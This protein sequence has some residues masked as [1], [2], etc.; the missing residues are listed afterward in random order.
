[1]NTWPT[2]TWFPLLFTAG[3]LMLTVWAANPKQTERNSARM[4]TIGFPPCSYEFVSRRGV[5][6]LGSEEVGRLSTSVKTEARRN[7]P[8]WRKRRTHPTE[9]RVYIISRIC[10]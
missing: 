3:T 9:S 6:F 2:E 7:S 10:D 1:M 8:A 4:R 5:V